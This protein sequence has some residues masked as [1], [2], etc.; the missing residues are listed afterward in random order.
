MDLGIHNVAFI[1]RYREF[2]LRGFKEKCLSYATKEEFLN[3]WKEIQKQYKFLFIK[4]SRS[5]KLETLVKLDQNLII[6]KLNEESKDA[7]PFF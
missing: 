7:L 2:Y 5:L 3:E 6:L 1:G 4:A